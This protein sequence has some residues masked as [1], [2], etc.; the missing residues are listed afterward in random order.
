LTENR[1][2]NESCEDVQP[3]SSNQISS[4]WISSVW[5]SYVRVCTISPYLYCRDWYRRWRDEPYY[6][7][8]RR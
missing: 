2:V 5:V 1:V 3:E 7:A 4:F 8:A 6:T